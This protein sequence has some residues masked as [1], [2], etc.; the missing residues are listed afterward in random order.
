MPTELRD[1]IAAE[2]RAVAVDPQLRSRLESIGQI[3]HV[4]TP[5]EFEA[6]IEAQ[7]WWATQLAKLVNSKS[8]Q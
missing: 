6:Q 4:G 1:W 3:L 2:I 8:M 7:R 5:A